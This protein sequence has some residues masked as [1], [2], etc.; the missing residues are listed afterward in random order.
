MRR[1]LAFYKFI[2]VDELEALR[3]ELLQTGTKLGLKGTILIA[4][5]GVNGTVVGAAS[6][7][8]E[9]TKLLQQRFGEIP[10][11]WSDLAQDNRGFFRFKVKIKPEIV[12]FGVDDLDLQQ[13]GE[14]VDAQRWNELLADPDVLVIDT[15]NEY[16]IDIGTFPSARSPQ[17]TNFREFP[18]WVNDQ[19]DPQEQ[20]QVAMFCT[21]GIR[22]E[23]AS[24]FMRQAGFE[25]V[26]Q[27]NGGI[28]K[29]LEDVDEQDN[30][31]QGEC[32]VFDQRVS[33]DNALNQGQYDQCYA[34]RH[35]L[36]KEDLVSD[37]YER[38]VQCPHCV[39]QIDQARLDN[40][41]QRQKQVELA[42]ARGE[43][44]IG[45]TQK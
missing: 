7:L 36:S 39:G 10:F 32:F 15:R 26:Y 8:N 30:R 2:Q 42:A 45:E 18:D 3:D 33:V 21:G 38:G 22:C 24:A 41:R 1:V 35:P 13:T 43:S 29:Y 9:L 19:L 23:K 20:K 12:S 25:K 34:C 27:L 5:E 4:H 16:E 14:H 44:H 31:W 17:T 6:A 28:L 40:F 37:V 11:K